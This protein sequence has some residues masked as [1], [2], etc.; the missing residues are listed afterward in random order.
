MEDRFRERRV[1]T[2]VNK[3]PWTKAPNG[4][5][6]RSHLWKWSPIDAENPDDPLDEIQEHIFV[7]R[8]KVTKRPPKEIPRSPRK[9]KHEVIEQVEE[10]ILVSDEDDDI[11]IDVQSI[12]VDTLLTPSEQLTKTCMDNN[13]LPETF[14]GKN[15]RH[16]DDPVEAV[17]TTKEGAFTVTETNSSPLDWKSVAKKQS[18][19]ELNLRHY[20][21]GDRYIG[22]I[23]AALSADAACKNQ[24]RRFKRFVFNSC[25]LS[26][27]GLRS[28]ANGLQSYGHALKLDLS[29]NQFGA[30][31]IFPINNMFTQQAPISHSLVSIDLSSNGL[32]DSCIVELFKSFRNCTSLEWLDLSKNCIRQKASS[33]IATFLSSDNLCPLKSLNLS[34]NQINK[35]GGKSLLKACESNKV[36]TELSLSWNSLSET[37]EAVV[38]L[39]AHNVSLR[40]LSLCF[41]GFKKSDCEFIIGCLRTSTSLL[42]L[43]ISG[44]ETHENVLDSALHQ[45]SE[46]WPVHNE[47]CVY[48]RYAP[49]YDD[50]MQESRESSV[51]LNNSCN[52]SNRR[53]IKSSS[54]VISSVS[55]NCFDR[56][57]WKRRSVCWVE[58]RWKE[59]TIEYYPGISGPSGSAVFLLVILPNKSS[60]CIPMEFNGEKQSV[61][62]D[63][64]KDFSSRSV[65]FG[66]SP[67]RKPSRQL[68]R[69]FKS[70]SSFNS[71]LQRRSSTK[72]NIAL[73]SIVEPTSSN[74]RQ[75]LQEMQRHLKRNVNENS[76]TTAIHDAVQ[77]R[78]EVLSTKSKNAFVNNTKVNSL[79]KHH[80][81]C[82]AESTLM[83]PPGRNFYKFVVDGHEVFARDRATYW[84]KF[85]RSMEKSE[86]DMPDEMNAASVANY[87]DIPWS[88]APLPH[89]G[90]PDPGCDRGAVK[91]GWCIQKSIFRTH[92][93]D[94]RA[95]LK[96][97]FTREWMTII[98]SPLLAELFEE[99]D[100]NSIGELVWAQYSDIV[101]AYHLIASLCPAKFAIE[102]EGLHTWLNEEKIMI[103]LEDTEKLFLQVVAEEFA[104]GIDSRGRHYQYVVSREVQGESFWMFRHHFIMFIM[105]LSIHESKAIMQANMNSSLSRTRTATFNS[106]RRG[107]VPQTRLDLVHGLLRRILS[108]RKNIVHRDWFRRGCFLLPDVVD[109][110][111]SNLDFL[112]TLFDNYSVKGH[113]LHDFV[114]ANRWEDVVLK[115]DNSDSFGKR[116]LQII[117]AQSKNASIEF[118]DPHFAPGLCFLEFL[119]CL[120][121]L[122]KLLSLANKAIDAFSRDS[123]ETSS[124]ESLVPHIQT[125]L[126]KLKR[127]HT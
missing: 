38:H 66:R 59:T 69:S 100:F 64:M 124:T 106:T 108:T 2:R 34:W 13:L 74:D 83:L 48:S 35:H 29:D 6:P 41:N 92:D 12:Q 30:S 121:R 55:N 1:K 57:K 84:A 40:K 67:T 32:T 77:T 14:W 113:V 50:T 18:P 24:R 120:A 98:Q 62:S 39:L 22:A 11:S 60:M 103:T 37:A 126:K 99:D 3:T 88:V 28:L 53:G 45:I 16:V 111:T 61:I 110:F 116:A 15:K 125:L 8:P 122:A 76:L 71:P 127:A 19:D 96:R 4:R 91:F 72:C 81:M 7:S 51:F 79:S 54:N 89:M 85:P 25:R 10:P 86:D 42:S 56:D 82:P 23:A 43:D 46:V 97:S 68:T 20:G 27:P 95:S 93:C 117:F 44:N 109:C 112:R 65:Q 52:N 119:E 17:V 115:L 75:E 49:P 78:E 102:L 87:I 31:G 63:D 9:I 118:D 5:F 107:T 90:D 105:A 101:S 47:F 58:G 21:I 80:P 70:Q 94:T 104:S 73:K 123:F 33:E 36:L 114:P 26:Q